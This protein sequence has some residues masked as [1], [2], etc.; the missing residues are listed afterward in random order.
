MELLQLRMQQDKI[1]EQLR[2]LQMHMLQKGQYRSLTK[3]SKDENGN[4]VGTL[5]LPLSVGIVG[6]II[7]VHP[8][9]K[10]CYKNLGVSSAQEL[11]CVMTATG[12]GSKL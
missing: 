2:L 11:A 3:W 9:A 1:A 10:V 12:L 8:I 7:N 5:E 4:L 6:G